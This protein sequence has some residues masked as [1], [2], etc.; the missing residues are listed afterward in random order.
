[1]GALRG[2]GDRLP[3]DHD[4]D[5]LLHQG[6]EGYGANLPLAIERPARLGRLEP[7]VGQ[8]GRQRRLGHA[9][10]AHRRDWCHRLLRQ[11]RENPA[12]ARR[13]SS[14]C[15]RLGTLFRQDLRPGTIHL[16]SIL[17]AR[18]C[19]TWPRAMTRP[20]AWATDIW[21]VGTIRAKRCEMLA[22]TPMASS[23]MAHIK[24][25]CTT[26]ATL[27]NSAR[28]MNAT[29]AQGHVWSPRGM[30]SVMLPL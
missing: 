13:R 23:S 21:R 14:H 24:P 27:A 7:Q 17:D 20:A 22:V 2:A 11:A 12:A 10:R 29:S 19:A 30:R 8:Y 5:W 6:H 25:P 28:G 26:P 16:H 1:M 15:L 4:P 9:G 18:A 3:G